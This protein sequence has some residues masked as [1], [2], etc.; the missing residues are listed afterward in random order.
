MRFDSDAAGERR[1]IVPWNLL[2]R[3]ARGREGMR[4]WR[5]DGGVDSL[6]STCRELKRCAFF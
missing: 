1:T 6:G 3:P 4:R 5:N 2:Y